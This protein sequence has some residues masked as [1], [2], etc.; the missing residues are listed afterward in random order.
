MVLR[1]TLTY[2]H[3][4]LIHNEIH[5]SEYYYPLSLIETLTAHRIYSKSTSRSR[6]SS[7][8]S[9]TRV[10]LSAHSVIIMKRVRVIKGHRVPSHIT[11]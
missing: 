4:L 5:Y 3:T 2:Y 6:D 10:A 1:V 7:L 9:Y 8:I 11:S